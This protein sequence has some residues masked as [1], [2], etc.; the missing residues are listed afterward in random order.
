IENRPDDYAINIGSRPVLSE[1]HTMRLG[2]LRHVV[3]VTPGQRIGYVT[4]IADNL[5]N[6][7]K[8]AALMQGVDLLFIE[9]AFAEADDKLAT[10]RAHLTTK[11]AGE[12][13]RSAGARR[14]E[15]FHFSARYEG[16]EDQMLTEVSR[17]F[18]QD[19]IAGVLTA[20]PL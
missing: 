8:I 5:A 1:R 17:A 6:R 19:G 3:T 14:V 20:R 18:T 4:D 13:A 16:Q 7:K 2:E 12:I 15:P 11:A 10:E 9:A